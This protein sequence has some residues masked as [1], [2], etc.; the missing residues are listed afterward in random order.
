MQCRMSSTNSTE[1]RINSPGVLYCIFKW[2]ISECVVLDDNEQ[3]IH[4]LFPLLALQ[5]LFYIE[6][7]FFLAIYPNGLKSIESRLNRL[8]D[9]TLHHV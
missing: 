5:T 3:C 4:L 7:I 2:F 8:V 9:T 6:T 1:C